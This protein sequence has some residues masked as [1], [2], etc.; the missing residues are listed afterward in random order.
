MESLKSKN[1]KLAMDLES[2]KSSQEILANQLSVKNKQMKDVIGKNTNLANK[3][4]ELQKTNGSL[5]SK[6]D[7][8]KD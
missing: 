7:Q 8:A 3:L 6:L 2:A 4:K 5:T 1:V